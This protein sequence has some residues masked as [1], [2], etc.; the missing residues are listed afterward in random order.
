MVLLVLGNLYGAFPPAAALVHLFVALL[1]LALKQENAGALT[2][3]NRHLQTNGIL[4]VSRVVA[5]AFTQ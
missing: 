4:A 1:A 5:Q 3:A 2:V